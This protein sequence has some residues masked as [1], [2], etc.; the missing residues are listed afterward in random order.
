M[1]R[2]DF[3]AIISSTAALVIQILSSAE[4]KEGGRRDLF[5]FFKWTPPY[6]S[7][8]QHF[9]SLVSFPWNNKLTRKYIYIYEREKK[10]KEES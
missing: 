7:Q 1:S 9:H 6:V 10:K 4:H 8:Q 5:Y 2:A 3:L